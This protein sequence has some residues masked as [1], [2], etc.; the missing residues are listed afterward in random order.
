MKLTSEARLTQF[1]TK[2]P[3]RMKI[4]SEISYRSKDWIFHRKDR[5]V[6]QSS[7]DCSFSFTSFRL[8]SFSFL[9]FPSLFFSFLLFRFISF[10]IQD[11]LLLS[12]LLSVVT[13]AVSVAGSWVDTCTGV[14]WKNSGS[15]VDK[16]VLWRGSGSGVD[17]GVLGR[18]S[19]S[20][21]AMA[22]GSNSPIMCP[23]GDL[24]EA[25]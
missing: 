9:L 5:T 21:T 14:L 4:R 3:D 17:T 7:I 20:G 12:G 1:N 22:V 15:G 23:S 18:G 13:G 19:G 11:P 25:N 16:G 10:Q 8:L 2:S 6:S 24:M